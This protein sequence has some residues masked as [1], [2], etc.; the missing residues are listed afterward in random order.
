MALLIA[1]ALFLHRIH[2]YHD[3]IVIIIFIFLMAIIKQKY[4]FVNVMIYTF[5]LFFFLIKSQSRSQTLVLNCVILFSND[6]RFD[7]I[8]NRYVQHFALINSIYTKIQF[9]LIICYKLKAICSHI[10]S[11]LYLNSSCQVSPIFYLFQFY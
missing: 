8:S 1:V 3:S 10:Y 11:T 2:Y 4:S 5:F 6:K 9:K 7:P